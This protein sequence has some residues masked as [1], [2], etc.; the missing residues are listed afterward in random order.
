MA[1]E[2]YYDAHMCHEHILQTIKEKGLNNKV[3]G[4]CMAVCPYT[5]K[6]LKRALGSR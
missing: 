6:Y 4:I 2:E 5:Q 3:C 1:R